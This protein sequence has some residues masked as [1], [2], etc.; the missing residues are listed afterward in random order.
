MTTTSRP[1]RSVAVRLGSLPGLPWRHDRGCC[2]GIV[3]GLCAQLGQLGAVGIDLA[4]GALGP[5]PQVGA[6]LRQFGGGLCAEVRQ[7]PIG[8]GT[9]P[10]GL[11]AGGF[12]RSLC[13]RR[14]LLR[15]PEPF[16]RLRCVPAGPLPIRLRRAYPIVGLRARPLDRGIP[17][18]LGGSNPCGSVLTAATGADPGLSLEPGPGPTEGTR[19]RRKAAAG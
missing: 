18:G 19:T 2:S 1:T 11:S 3:A 14:F 10:L 17:V 8:L 16:L 12:F 9:Y 13:T 15:Q 4:L 7:H 6:D 5:C